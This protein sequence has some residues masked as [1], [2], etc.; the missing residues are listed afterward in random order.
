MI[1]V[2]AINEDFETRRMCL[3][4]G[5]MGEAAL[6]YNGWLKA[7]RGEHPGLPFVPANKIVVTQALRH[8]STTWYVH[9]HVPGAEG[10]GPDL[11]S[12]NDVDALIRFIAWAVSDR[13]EEAEDADQVPAVYYCAGPFCAGYRYRASEIGH[14]AS[15][16]TGPEADPALS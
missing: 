7:H 3:V 13:P 16:V 6:E 2:D 5:L 14:P 8:G 4:A 12:A 15:C 9:V 1:D 11:P 10:L